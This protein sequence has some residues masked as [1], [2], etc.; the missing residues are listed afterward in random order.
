MRR[1]L[2]LPILVVCL[3]GTRAGP[4]SSRRTG[5]HLSELDF[6]GT[7]AFGTVAAGSTL[8]ATV[9]GLG[10][11]FAAGRLVFTGDTTTFRITEFNGDTESTPFDCEVGDFY[12]AGPVDGPVTFTVA[13]RFTDGTAKSMTVAVYSADGTVDETAT[14]AAT[15]TP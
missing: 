9:T 4:Q 10:G 11:T 14:A 7:L 2:L 8:T 12:F 1:L 3:A 15:V 6:T 5:A 13:T